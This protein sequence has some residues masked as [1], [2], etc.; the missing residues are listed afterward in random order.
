MDDRRRVM[1]DVWVQIDLM[2]ADPKS[3]RLW[4]VFEM[5]CGSCDKPIAQ[6]MNTTH[7]LAVVYRSFKGTTTR[8]APVTGKH[9]E[10]QAMSK[11]IA[12][13]LYDGP[14]ICFC[15]CTRT[16]LEGGDF[17]DPIGKGQRR[18]IRRRTDT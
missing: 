2:A 7:G 1:D 18:I 5:Y 11:L 13:M 10:S 14:F 12:R 15:G 3:W 8:P 6:V 4:R 16:V 9:Y 17:T